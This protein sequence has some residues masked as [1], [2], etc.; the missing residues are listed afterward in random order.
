MKLE[1][2]VESFQ[3]IINFIVV[4]ILILLGIVSGILTGVFVDAKYDAY[5]ENITYSLDNIFVNIFGVILLIIIMSIALKRILKNKGIFIIAFIHFLLGIFWAL[6]AKSPLRAD[7]LMVSEIAKQFLSNNYQSLDV[8]GYL[9]HHPM[10]LS[11][12]YYIELIYTIFGTQNDIILWV[13][14]SLCS[15][16]TFIYLYKIGTLIFDKEKISLNLKIFIALFFLLDLLSI[17]V[18]GNLIG[19]TF[20]MIALYNLFKFYKTGKIKN[21]FA[22]VI[23]MILSIVIKSNYVIY[24]IA[25]SIS[26]IIYTIKNKKIKSFVIVLASIIVIFTGYKVINYSF[27]MIT[28][29]KYGNKISEGDPMIS[30]I[31]MGMA[32]KIDRASGWYNAGVNVEKSYAENNYDV[33]KTKESSKQYIINRISYFAH[34]PVTFVKYYL[35][36][37]ISTW[38][39]P[40]FQAIWTCKPQ[41]AI[42][43]ELRI[44]I[45]NHII[46]KS[47]YDGTLNKIVNKY[48]DVYAIIVFLFSG[49]YILKN[50]NN[51]NL[52][53]FTILL[54]FFGGFCFHIL[55]ETKCIYVIPYYILLLPFSAGGLNIVLDAFNKENI[56][57]YI[58]KVRGKN[59]N[60]K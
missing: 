16:I 41:D 52:E 50:R 32:D 3:K 55:W 59:E 23:F 19:L 29:E 27:V 1:K 40:S 6:Y 37:V 39:E 33:D 60:S 53:K 56:K 43:D 5:S 17:Y 26:L 31:Q 12:V 48:F 44:D 46:L 36:K 10:Q 9:F 47:F 35:D 54:I 21:V 57:L 15:M 13:I 49:I 2:L 45:E 38:T 20:A 58:D 24:F 51:I 28:E 25:I 30:Y 34:N 42:T 18:Y 8:G 4:F 22:L 11:I 7:Q 14:N